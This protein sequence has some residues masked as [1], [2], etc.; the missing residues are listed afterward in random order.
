MKHDASIGQVRSPLIEA[1]KA[2]FGR[3]YRLE[4]GA[5][6]GLVEPPIWS[7]RLSR[8]LDIP[9]NQ[10]AAELSVFAD[11]GALQRQ[12]LSEFDRRK[13]YERLPHPL[14]E[15]CREEFERA[16]RMKYPENGHELLQAYW[17]DVLEAAQPQVPARDGTDP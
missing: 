1:S 15:F 13:T 10:V 17:S 4:I 3:Q 12:P 5:V 14:W 2:L 9:E 16:I 7:R 11:R 8:L 6:T